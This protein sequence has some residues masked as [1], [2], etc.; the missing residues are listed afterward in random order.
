MKTRLSVAVLAVALL[1]T[2]GCSSDEPA[3][4][5]SDPPSQVTTDAPEVPRGSDDGDLSGSVGDRAVS[6]E[7]SVTCELLQGDNV[8]VE[9]SG[10]DDDSLDVYR[11]SGGRLSA[12]DLTS[13]DLETTSRTAVGDLRIE[14]TDS[15]YTV[16]GSQYVNGET[17]VD[18]DLTITCPA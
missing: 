3:R 10:P 9:A 14:Q 11:S 7:W 13:G 12:F 4:T 2:T 15:G 16:S 18:V 8:H 6:G 1:T 5:I 17:E